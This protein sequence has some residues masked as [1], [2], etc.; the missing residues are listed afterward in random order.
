MRPDPSK[1]IEIAGISAPLIG[2]YDAPDPGP[3]EPV[4]RPKEGA[5]VC[6]FSFYRA[7]LDGRTAHLRADSFGCGGC[8]N[9]F[10]DV[11]TRSHE[12][13]IDFLYGREGLKA[14]RELMEEWIDRSMRYRPKHDN[15]FAGPLK[16]DAWE[17]LLSVTFLVN[18]DQLALLVYGTHYHASPRD[19]APLKAPFSSGCGQ[20][21]NGF[22]D[23]EIA[24]GVIGGTDVAMRRFLPPEI[25]AVTVTKTMFERLC[26]LDERSFL[27]KPFWKDLLASRRG[28]G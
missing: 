2:L 9:Q 20:L 5:Q 17:Y 22:D 10:F 25:L 7:W 13:F 4:V 15:I 24:Q 21:L 12:E 11:Q 8:G 28:K 1:L 19:P 16:P 18:P 3:F 23:L 14:S 6:L 26:S 27:Y